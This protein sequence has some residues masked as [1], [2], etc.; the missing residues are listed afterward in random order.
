M[1]N[2]YRIRTQ[3]GVDKAVNV[4][5]EQ[6]FESLEILSLKILQS[7]IYTRQCS[8]YG[9]V[10]GRITANNGFG[11]PNVKVSVFIPLS[12]EDELDPV[13][14]ELYPYKTLNDLN[15]EGYRYNLLPYEPSHDGHTPT[16]TFPS[17]E[18]VLVEPPLIEVFDKYYKYTAKTNESGDYMIFGVPVG[19]Q[20]IHID[21]DLSDI[22][23]FSLAPQD[24]IR[25]NLATPSQLSGSKFK[26]STNLGELPQIKQANR[27]IEVE[28]LW[29]QPEVC[30]LGITR[31]DFD[32]SQEF[33]IKIEPAAVFMGSILSNE[34]KGLVKR[35]CK[36]NKKTGNFC[37][38]VT[39]PGEILA[40][41]QT[42]GLDS[43]GRPV[44]ERFDLENGGK[45]IDENGTWM[46]DVP[47][48][49]D[50][51]YTSESG[52]RLVS[53]DPNIGIP[54]KAKYRFKVKWE[55]PPTLSGKIIRGAF[56]VPNIKEWGWQGDYTQDPTIQE[57]S[58]IDGLF[59]SNCQA[60]D[61]NFINTPDYLMAKASYAFSLDW[62]DY[63]EGTYAYEMIQD[64]ISCRDRFFEMKHSKVY[65]VSQLITEHKSNASKYQ[66]IG[67]KDVLNENC[68]ATYNTFPTND[69]QK[70]ND[71]LYQLFTLILNIF[72]PILFGI[73]YFTHIL[74]L[75]VC[76]IA[77]IVGLLK[78]FVCGVRDAAC[79]LADIPI[80]GFAFR[81]LCNLLDKLCS[82]LEEL[83]DSLNERCKNSS[84]KLP[85]IC[86]DEC[87]V[88][89]CG[90]EGESGGDVD[91]DDL[92]LGGL[93][94]VIESAGVS[95]LFSNFFDVG[96]WGCGDDRSIYFAF[97][98]SGGLYDSQNPS[99]IARA[100][101]PVVVS[102]DPLTTMFTTSLTYPERF[103]L[104]NT[105]AKYF[106]T[107][108]SG[109][110]PGG[111]WNRVK[112]SFNTGMNDSGS[113]W[114]ADSVVVFMVK[115]TS[116]LDFTPGNIF[117]PVRKSSSQDVNSD[118]TIS[119]E[120]NQ[121]GNRATTGT[122]YGNPITDSGGNILYYQI[123]NQSVNWAKWD[124]SGNDTTNYTITGTPQNFMKFPID[125]E[126]FQVIKST[127]VGEFLANSVN[128]SDN[129]GLRD[130]ILTS[131]MRGEYFTVNGSVVE[132]YSSDV[133]VNTEISCFPNFEN[134]KLIFMVRGVDP[135]SSRTTCA[136]DLSR[137]YGTDSDFSTWTTNE[138][139][140]VVGEFKLNIPIQNKL[141]NVRHTIG[142]NNSLDSYTSNEQ[143]LFFPSY[144]FLPDSTLYTNFSSSA[145]SLYSKYDA[146]DVG[147]YSS[148][149]AILTNNVNGLRIFDANW[150]S[151]EFYVNA[152]SSNP[153]VPFCLS[154][155]PYP[156]F[157]NPDQAFNYQ[158]TGRNRGYFYRE[159]VEGTGVMLLDASA[160]QPVFDGGGGW[161]CNTGTITSYYISER[162]SPSTTIDFSNNVR[163]VMRGDRLPTSSNTQ[164]NGDLSF[165]FMQ[166]Q[167]FTMY[168]VDDLGYVE[169]NIDDVTLSDES[170]DSINNV[171]NNPTISG[172]GNTLSCDNLIPLRCYKY[173]EETGA[174]TIA[175]ENDDCYTNRYIIGDVSFG[176][177]DK[178]LVNGCYRLV[179]QPIIS[180]FMDF[181]LLSE[182]AARIKLGVAA[183]RGIFGHIFT[184]NWINGSLFM[185]PLGNS[186]RYT[187]FNDD[188]PSQPYNCVCS[189]LVFTDLETN[190]VFY[191][192]SPYK[193]P[194][195][196]IGKANGWVPSSG[197]LLNPANI[198]NLQNP[199]TIMDLGP[200]TDYTY[201]LVLND[202]YIGYVMNRLGTTSFQDVSDLL[203]QFILSRLVS[204]SIIGLI[205]QQYGG[206][207]SQSAGQAAGGT[208][209]TDPVMRMFSRPREKVDGDYAQ[210]L[211]I[212]S[213]VGVLG[214]D[215]DEY[216]T[217]N[218]DG[219]PSAPQGYVYS[220]PSS[221][222]YNVFGIFYNSNTQ[223]RDWLSPHRL[224]VSE[225]SQTSNVCT[226]QNIP[227]F[228]QE[229]PFYQWDIRENEGFEIGETP[230]PDSIFGDQKNDWS[231]DATVFFSSGYQSMDRLNSDYMQPVDGT[232]YTYHKG[233]IY[234]VENGVISAQPPQAGGPN[235]I[236]TPSGPYYF[237]FGLL[238]GKSAYDRFLVKWIKTDV[239]EF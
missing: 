73:V 90:K 231:T 55:Q 82:P 204:Q 211:A 70:N 208:E 209:I 170:Q 97:L 114:H 61:I 159:I 29:G 23:E 232:I 69:G 62:N 131:D 221:S 65:T 26:S 13:I 223:L 202:E 76:T 100:P 119:T 34:E 192:S 96:R 226:Y 191:R 113:T 9:V 115:D 178:V 237:Y 44:L 7:Q 180:L 230:N 196:F 50:F 95:A 101:Q 183:C 166:N 28:P 150:F 41:R 94:D 173:D 88:S 146:E 86:Y 4:L 224:V 15:D 127:T 174:V 117:T 64:A 56:L 134:Q 162:Y 198:K 21:V 78:L 155:Y 59:S 99:L 128:T 216:F 54:T 110:N 92:G 172:A 104:F 91:V 217:P 79:A 1:T 214:Y 35:N 71:F 138:E 47:M 179:T 52:E 201:Q 153:T 185:Y 199:T 193:Y 6:D 58:F 112:A 19:E 161:Y 176:S 43:G 53:N 126:Y 39:G 149:P 210:M 165:S 85:M 32:L 45:C 25:L 235:R 125:V 49:L 136:F 8:D 75:V 228:T 184:N 81:P 24:L 133:R 152:N 143:Y 46:T 236:V 14:S 238:R 74:L 140:L 225:N 195:G 11:L 167:V 189:Q 169:S 147:I 17:R 190:N 5:L 124:G 40:V 212:N 105:K 130:R 186:V 123:D 80:V 215:A 116:G 106:D 108:V 84:L 120:N 156:P 188:P 31:V 135:Y 20:T 200:R 197:S 3:V 239:L 111:G 103:N 141:R 68:E 42:I 122:T 181:Y 187:G 66:Y 145:T 154:S 30:Y 12:S 160:M 51:V 194:D 98:V 60:P 168:P 144:N 158:G 219:V 148:S 233:Y 33:G 10:V 102:E 163:I 57:Q 175:P 142:T 67:I 118:L 220:N 222:F 77:K 129:A 48:N 37:S 22:G 63:G 229:V 207:I 203:N 16:G 2:S 89:N 38:L 132:V 234:N 182:W 93:T 206:V 218:P 164:D 36:V 109:D 27:T 18:D 72:I 157:T 83:Y 213:Q 171:L 139:H 151:R 107:D 205:I 121:F 87:E 227:I 177:G 137:L